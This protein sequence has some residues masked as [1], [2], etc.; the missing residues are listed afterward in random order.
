MKEKWPSLDSE[1]PQGGGGGQK[2]VQRPLLEADGEQPA[3]G[4]EA[5]RALALQSGTARTHPG[6][7]R[8]A[9]G[10]PKLEEGSRREDKTAKS[11]R[12]KRPFGGKASQRDRNQESE[13]TEVGRK[14]FSHSG[15]EEEP[16]W[17]QISPKQPSEPDDST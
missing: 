5:I 16:R 9:E 17:P 14:K 7:G 6:D 2:R 10:E 4:P 1:M 15:R 11:L 13:R 8:T 3:L 12:Q